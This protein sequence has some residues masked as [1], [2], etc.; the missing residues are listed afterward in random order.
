MK[1]LAMGIGILSIPRTA[2]GEGY[3]DSSSFQRVT[4]AVGVDEKLPR[5]A[6]PE[7]DSKCCKER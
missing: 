6:K 2:R 7:T 4:I 5:K 1:K 3:W